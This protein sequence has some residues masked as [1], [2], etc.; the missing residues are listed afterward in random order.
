MCENIRV[1]PPLGVGSAGKIFATMLLHFGFSA[2]KIFA[3][4]LLHFMISFKLMQH[5][6][7]PKKL[8]FDLL[9]PSTWSWGCCGQNICYHIAAIV[10][11]FKLICKMTMFRK[12]WILTYWPHPQ[13]QGGCLVMVERLFLAV[14]QGCLRF[15]IVVFPDHTH[16][17]CFQ[18]KYLLPC[19]CILNS[20]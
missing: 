13:D 7:V 10:I 17:F 18:A 4:S 2:G 19:C 3:T 16:Y 8:N 1:P 14:P 12:S 6:H 15:V 20:L 11:L 9:T 5:A